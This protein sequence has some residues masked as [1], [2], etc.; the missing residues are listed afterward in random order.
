MVKRQ[1]ADEP[2]VKLGKNDLVQYNK[3]DAQMGYVYAVELDL[4]LKFPSLV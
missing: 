4:R 2:R 3:L 1:I